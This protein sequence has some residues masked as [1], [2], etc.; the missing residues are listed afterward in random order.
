[1]LNMLDIRTIF[2]CTAI[3]A[4]AFA[5]LLLGMGRNRKTYPG[6]GE[7][8]AT[9]VAFTFL[10]LWQAFRD[11]LTGSLPVVLGN[12]IVCCTMVLLVQG[13][14]KFCGL[15]NRNT[16]IYIVSA[17]YLCLVAYYYFVSENFWARTLLAGTYLAVMGFYAAIPFVRSAPKGRNFS[18]RY[19]ALILLFGASINAIRV[20]AVTRMP[21]VKSIFFPSKINAAASLTDL[22]S[23]IGVSFSFYFLMHERQLAELSDANRELEHEVS[24]RTKA[25]DTLRA[26]RERLQTEVAE[27]TATLRASEE[28]YRALFERNLAAV[29]HASHDRLLDCNQEMCR[30]LGY[31]REELLAID[32]C[33]LGLAPVELLGGKNSSDQAEELTKHEL[34]LRRKDGSSITVL[35][36]LTL[37]ADH[38]EL[39]SI[40]AGVMLDIS[41]VRLL[42]QQLAQSQK[43]EALGLLT[44]G[45][46]HD[47][48]NIL[49]SIYSYSE[50]AM[51]ACNDEDSVHNAV[52]EIRVAAKRA[53]GLTQR[54]LAFGRKQV[55]TPVPV[56]LDSILSN[57]LGM[58]TRLIGEDIA[59][60]VAQSEDLWCAKVDPS[61]IEQI[62]VNL[63]V[64]AREAMPHGGKLLVEASNC[65]LDD[66]FVRAHS[67]SRAG[68]YVALRVSDTGCG[69]SDDIQSRIFEP[70]F[71]TKPGFGTGLGL[72][73]V[74]GIVKQSDGYI[75]VESEPGV[76]TTFTLYLPRTTEAVN[77]EEQASPAST[78]NLHPV[79]SRTILLVEDEEQPRVAMVEYLSRA[80]F[81][82]VSSSS[83]EEALRICERL[84]AD[85]FNVLL[86]DIIMPGMSGVE[87]ATKF[88]DRY[89][90]ARVVFMSGYT[91]DV[92]SRSGFQAH[93][94]TMMNKPFALEDLAV[95]L[96]V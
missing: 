38:S 53:A 40:V 7:W 91:D 74:Y 21:N 90:T 25:E 76:G 59:L 49:M 63:V 83:G 24:E 35:L 92:L 30:M 14:R 78:H 3:L 18:Y 75:D 56:K 23:L 43:L 68:Q 47:F 46:A 48:N 34:D 87:L 57:L 93:Q 55:M 89:P 32:L 82:V 1:M 36:I 65:E 52:K 44:G 4:G 31:S 10:F 73:T 22:I 28:R 72:S 61:Q 70:F 81:R 33:A 84:P 13:M 2:F 96:R 11:H 37:V 58:L 85:A 45:I 80:G 50:L 64:N 26:H 60:E 94:V 12:F 62:V 71:T 8:T 95:K 16:L 66:A 5:L 6:Y 41:D 67:G 86:T 27:Q 17:V 88:R 15:Q 29:F 39:A 77:T 54:L 20:I 42:Q 69:M 79:A 9:E 19:T 51:S